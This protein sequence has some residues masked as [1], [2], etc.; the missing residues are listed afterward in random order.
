MRFKQ[1]LSPLMASFLIVA[2]VEAQEPSKPIGPIIKYKYPAAMTQSS[3]VHE[4]EIDCGKIL[5]FPS[6]PQ[7]PFLTCDFLEQVD[8]N[9]QD[10]C[11][12]TDRGKMPSTQPEQEAACGSALKLGVWH[13]ADQHGLCK[14]KA[15]QLARKAGKTPAEIESKYGKDWEQSTL[16]PLNDVVKECQRVMGYELP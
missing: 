4:K 10:F 1:V 15:G 2:A 12:V 5:R 6:Y 8:Q 14:K 7:Y 3:G 9:G 11:N 13:F 16:C